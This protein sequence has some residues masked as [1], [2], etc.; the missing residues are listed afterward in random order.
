[1]AMEGIVL[2]PAVQEVQATSHALG[3]SLVMVAVDEQLA[4]VIVLKPTLR[5]EISQV[6]A[7]L[8]ARGLTLYI[9]SGDQEEPTRRLAEQVGIDHYQANTLPEQKASFIETLQ[10]QGRHVCFVGDGINDG[11]AL[12]KANVSISLRGATTVATDT[13]QIVLMDAT[14]QHL[15]TLFHLADAFD[16]SM[17]RSRAWAVAPGV[18]AIAGVFLWHFGFLAAATIYVFSLIGGSLNAMRPAL[19]EQKGHTTLITASHPS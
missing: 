15:P 18:F 12:K 13:A 10:A 6:V 2:P 7:A 16:G 14:L 3:Y 5:P 1:M 11:I 19:L 8:H 9:L 4:G 17:R